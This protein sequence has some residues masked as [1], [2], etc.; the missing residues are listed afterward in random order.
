M[1]ENLINVLNDTDYIIGLDKSNMGLYLFTQARDAQESFKKSKKIFSVLKYDLSNIIAAGMGGSGMAPHAVEFLFK[2]EFRIPYSVSQDYR[3]SNFAS[4]K[5]LLIAISD[6]GET[7]EVISQYYEAQKRNTKIITIAQKSRLIELAKKDKVAYFDYT[8]PVPSRA[9]FGFMFGS[10]LACLENIGAILP[11]NEKSLN[12]AIEI[13]DEMKSCIGIDTPYEK[14]AAKQIALSIM[15]KIPLLYME[16]PFGSLGSRFAKMM[17]ENAGLFSFYNQLPELRHNEIMS[18]VDKSSLKSNLSLI[19]LRD[20]RSYSR[21]E[22]EINEI[23]KVISSN[24]DII[25][26][27]ARGESKLARFFSLQYMMDM[28]AYYMAILVGKD[29]SITPALKDLKKKLREGAIIPYS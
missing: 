25:E 23:K 21:M 10:A 18:L 9:S 20:G 3:L 16:P 5:T 22:E 11:G 4:D 13:L 1:G 12:E 19:L 29:P 14:N 17:N 27:R 26:L 28:V 8:T 2:D 24:Y 7:E 6:S 15:N